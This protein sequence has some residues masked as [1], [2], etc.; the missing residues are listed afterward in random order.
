VKLSFMSAGAAHALVQANARAAGIEVAGTFGAVGAMLERL[1]AGDPCDV[2]IL[3]RAQVDA[4]AKSERVVASTVAPLGRVATSIAVLESDPPPD[5]ASEEALRSALLAAD[6]IY[7]PDP[8]RATAGIHFAKVIATLGIA[9]R[10]AGRVRNFPNGATSM[11]EM[12]GAGGHPI[13][14]TQAT[15]ILATPGIRL[16]G[17]LP[18]GL[19]L[20]T[21]YAAAVDARSAQRQEAAAFVARLTAN[22]AKR[23]RERMGFR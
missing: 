3:T 5:V 2:V 13:G 4:L 10:V 8:S 11:R 22:A 23:E 9:E 18:R 6:A 20:E 1:D 19:D 21:T 16:V 7:F 17:P 14:C 15:E 12:A